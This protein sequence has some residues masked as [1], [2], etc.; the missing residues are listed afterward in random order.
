MS[1]SGLNHRTII[2][3]VVT[4]SDGLDHTG[5]IDGTVKVA[6]KSDLRFI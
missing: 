3:F 5:G 1:D 2:L 4:I 6:W